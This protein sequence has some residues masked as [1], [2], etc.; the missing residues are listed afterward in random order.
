MTEARPGPMPVPMSG[1]DPAPCTPGEVRVSCPPSS[2]SP[3]RVHFTVPGKPSPKARART[4][5]TGHT[6]TP[7]PTQ[8]AEAR[9]LECFLAAH[10]G[11]DPIVGPVRLYVHAFFEPPVSW[12]K[13]DKAAA[14]DGTT[15]PTGRPDWDNIAKLVTDALN[16][17]AYRD[18]S[19][20]VEAHVHKVFSPTAALMVTIEA[21]P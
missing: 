10:P 19:Q 11:W 14:L 7:K 1:T 5:K 16:E 13:K 4:T 17:V 15:Y 2:P 12:S 20:I 8:L 18:D 9:V 21:I 3:R 6:Y